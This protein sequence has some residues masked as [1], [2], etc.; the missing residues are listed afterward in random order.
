MIPKDPNLLYSF[1]NMKLRDCYSSLENMCEDMDL[2]QTA[3][4]AGL[5]AA[6]MTYD[7]EHNR[8]IYINE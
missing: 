5:E 3:L 1:M 7:A 2:D 8:V 4:L 6:G